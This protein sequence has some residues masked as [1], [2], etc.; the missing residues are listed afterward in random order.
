MRSHAGLW[1]RF[2]IGDRLP[3]DWGSA[4][5]FVV[6][7]G[8][9]DPSALQELL[10]RLRSTFPSA[11]RAVLV[12]PLAAFSFGAVGALCVR[13]SPGWDMHERS[14][15][16]PGDTLGDGVRLP[17]RLP[18]RR[19]IWAEDV[20]RV[21]LDPSHGTVDRVDIQGPVLLDRAGV[22]NALSLRNGGP[23]GTDWLG[24]SEVPPDPDQDEWDDAR[25]G[26]R[27]R[28]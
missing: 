16:R 22:A 21:L 26:L 23:C 12:S 14:L 8:S 1:Q 10:Q 9:V 17:R 7:L 4:G 19:W 18:S 24:R 3:N 2:E 11:A 6:T 15:L 5:R 13:A 25:W 28:L 20:A 27:R